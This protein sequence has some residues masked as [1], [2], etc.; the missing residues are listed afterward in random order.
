MAGEAGGLPKGVGHRGWPGA[1]SVAEKTHGPTSLFGGGQWQRRLSLFGPFET[2]MVLFLVTTGS[3]EHR[4]FFWCF[5]S[6]LAQLQGLNQVER[7]GLPA[8]LPRPP[9]G[10]AARSLRLAWHS[11]AMIHRVVGRRLVPK[12]EPR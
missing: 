1:P 2:R 9:G 5:E 7:R 12:M 6:F 11:S 8:D 10:F 4:V 3:L